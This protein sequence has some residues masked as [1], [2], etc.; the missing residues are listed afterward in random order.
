MRTIA[1]WG[2]FQWGE[3][4]WG[5][6]EEVVVIANTI[7]PSGIASQETFGT[8]RFAVLGP[9]GIAS[10]EFVGFPDLI[11]TPGA[12]G[13]I[14]PTSIGSDEAFG[15]ATLTEGATIFPTGIPSEFDMDLHTVGAPVA[16][17]QPSGIASA[18]AFGRPT[19]FRLANPPVP[20]A[21]TVT[22]KKLCSPLGLIRAEV[23]VDAPDPAFILPDV[24]GDF[25]LGGIRGPCPTVL[26]TRTSPFVYV[27]AAHP[28]Q[29]ITNVYVND[30]EQTGG[31]STSPAVDLGNGFQVAVITFTDQPAGVVSWRG[32]GR[33]DD[34]GVLI[35][36]AVDQLFTLLNH[37]AGYSLADFDAGLLAE[38]RARATLLGWTPAWVFQDDQQVQNW[39]TDLLFNVMGFWRVSGR[40]Q[41]QLYLDDGL[42]PSG[43][44]IVASV[45]AARDCVDGDDGVT[46]TAD[47]SHLVNKVIAY[48]LY[49]WTLGQ[50]SSR[51]TDLNDDISINA[52]GELRKGVTLRGLRVMEQVEQWARILF[53]RQS[54][55]HRVEGAL[56]HFTIEGSQLIHLAIGDI[57]AFSWPY[58]PRRELGNPYYNQ[59]LRALTVIHSFERGGISAIT[60]VDTGTFVNRDGV[61]V[62]EPLAL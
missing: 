54:F 45:V 3:A 27:A 8:P 25:A 4:Q 13:T 33:M 22:A 26:V 10:E 9:V 20:A 6:I 17:I 53:A 48:Y 62:L 49:S 56:V 30:V 39:V 15:T 51:L 57:F 50:P 58:G 29:A 44:E 21:G 19:L 16:T 18:E 11:G 37:R 2:K 32:Q 47:R 41:L 7:L 14:E 43:S 23:F 12:T 34:D 52:H 28:V 36:N 42:T 60:A 38:A 46:F 1:Q 31:F 40:A 59:L 61:R 55:A 5:S 35:T 24:Y